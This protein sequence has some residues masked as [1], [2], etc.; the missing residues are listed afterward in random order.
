MFLAKMKS[1]KE[2]ITI[3]QQLHIKWNEN[4]LKKITINS[5]SKYDIN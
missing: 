2:I 1:K 3:A 4:Y 5:Y